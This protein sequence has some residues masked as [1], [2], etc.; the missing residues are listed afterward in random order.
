MLSGSGIDDVWNYHRNIVAY[1]PMQDQVKAFN[2][3]S[4][5][6]AFINLSLT[7]MQ[8]R[9]ALNRAAEGFEVYELK[10]IDY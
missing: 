9:K 3:V 10:S 1:F 7:E 5:H 8:I 2:E 6:A 4:I